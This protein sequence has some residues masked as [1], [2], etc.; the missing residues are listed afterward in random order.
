MAGGFEYVHTTSPCMDSY[1]I[2]GVNVHIT[3]SPVSKMDT[4]V[5]TTVAALQWVP[6]NCSDKL[7]NRPVCT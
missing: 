4:F 3:G 5:S 1:A 7:W 6:L 2:V